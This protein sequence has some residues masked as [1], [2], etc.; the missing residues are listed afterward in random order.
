MDFG[1]LHTQG[2]SSGS[3]SFIQKIVGIEPVPRKGNK[4]R[5][6]RRKTGV[7]ENAVKRDAFTLPDT[8]AGK[9]RFFRCEKK[10]TSFH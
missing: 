2:G 9:D 1:T 4:K 7:S 3:N 10:I 6:G 8:G 5:S